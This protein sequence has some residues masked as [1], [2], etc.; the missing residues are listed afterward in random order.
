MRIGF[1]LV[2][3]LSIAGCG[4]SSDSQRLPI[5]TACAPDGPTSSACGS[6]PT[7]FCDSDHPNGYC[8]K[9]CHKDGDCPSG[10]VCAGA[11]TVSPGECHKEC[12]QAS[13]ATDCRL[14]EGYVCKDAPSDASHDY[15]DVPEV[16]AGDGG[17]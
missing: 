16:E 9:S 7:F 4:G 14:S 6:F 8:K 1:A 11:G 2:C 12:T 17:A 15:C 5:G 10:S 13:K 3:L